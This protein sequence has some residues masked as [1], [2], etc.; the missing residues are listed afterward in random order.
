[1]LKEESD[2]VMARLVENRRNNAGQDRTGQ[3]R[4]G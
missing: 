1:M 4:T 3:D 2:I